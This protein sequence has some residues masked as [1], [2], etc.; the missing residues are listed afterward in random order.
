[1]T[2]F[3]FVSY[4]IRILDS[5]RVSMSN[6]VLAGCHPLVW[7]SHPPAAFKKN[8]VSHILFFAPIDEA[9]FNA[10]REANYISAEDYRGRR[11]D[12]R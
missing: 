1:M 7:L 6:V 11:V 8:C 12:E 4:E 2:E 5:D 3:W 10:T 9:T